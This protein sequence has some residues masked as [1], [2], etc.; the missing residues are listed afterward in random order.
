VHV[1]EGIVNDDFSFDSGLFVGWMVLYDLETGKRLCHS[2]L[3]AEN[4]ESV[5]FREGRFTSKRK[6]AEAAVFGDFEDNLKDAA[7][8]A[9]KKMNGKLKLGYKLLE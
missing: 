3:A 6:K 4:S 2:T 5:S 7:S 8:A 9:I 1:D